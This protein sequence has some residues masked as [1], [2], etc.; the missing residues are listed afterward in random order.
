MRL[1]AA[2]A[3]SAM[4]VFANGVAAG[5]THPKPTRAGP[6][7][8]AAFPAK[9]TF[10]DP[11]AVTVRVSRRA[12]ALQLVLQQLTAAVWVKR[13]A[14]TRPGAG[15]FVLS[16]SPDAWQASLTLRVE[17]V[18]AG[19][20]VW[21]S[22]AAVVALDPHTIFYETPSLTRGDGT[23][24]FS[25]P[26]Q[27]GCIAVPDDMT[28]CWMYGTGTIDQSISS[29]NVG[30]FTGL[31]PPDPVGQ[32]QY[33]HNNG[34]YGSS[35]CQL[36]G[37]WAGGMLDKND[38]PPT[39][40]YYGW[41]LA[42]FW[43]VPHYKPWSPQYASTQLP[44]GPLFR[45]QTNW[46]LGRNFLG[47]SI[48]YGEICA[49]FYDGGSGRSM[50]WC[51][52]PWDSRGADAQAE[53]IQFNGFS[54]G[55]DIVDS[56]FGTGTHFATPHCQSQTRGQSNPNALQPDWYAAYLPWSQFHALTMKINTEFGANYSSDPENYYLT[57]VLAG[58]EMYAPGSTYGWI[59]S[60]VGN[61]T[62][63]DDANPCIG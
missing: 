62:A 26:Y 18:R 19:R 10:G 13:T 9:A 60:R 14:V 41:Q 35:A 56:Y 30:D 28:V 1:A 44:G 25:D 58:G 22:R 15:R 31:N 54:K 7:F 3:L 27:C 49:T 61:L 63:M 52:H 50:W 8:R 12:R 6:V 45:L 17:A 59:A 29:W 51:P 33:G 36:D 23:D 37:T 53:A 21:R 11:I 4:L 16:F 42:Y 47:T 5:S 43:S 34:R 24:V 46:D 40:T 48:Q 2:L 57:A 20:V 39:A 38:G 32:Y 55:S